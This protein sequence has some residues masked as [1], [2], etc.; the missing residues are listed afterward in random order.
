MKRIALVCVFLAAALAADAR[1]SSARAELPY[2]YEVQLGYSALPFGTYP[3]RFPFALD[4]MAFINPTLGDLYEDYDTQTFCTGVITAGF[5]FHFRK[6]FSLDL[7][8]GFNGLWSDRMSS[9]TDTKVGRYSG[10][11]LSFVPKARFTYFTR[12][13]VRMYSAIGLGVSGG[14][15][16]NTAA[17]GIVPHLTLFGISVGKDVFGLCEFGVGMDYLGRV[18]I[19]Y[20]F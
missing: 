4:E 10:L 12:P 9:V 13:M 19:G 6:W 16:R 15:Y 20:R 1:K 3:L 8:L 14:I 5:S 2:K 7:S 17:V 18:G 11:I